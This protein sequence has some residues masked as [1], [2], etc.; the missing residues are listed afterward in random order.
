MGVQNNVIKIVF[1]IFAAI[2]LL[3]LGIGITLG[4]IM[5][6]NQKEMVLHEAVITE[7]TYEKHNDSTTHKVYVDYMFDDV[8]YNHRNLGYW[9]SGMYEGKYIEIYVDPNSPNKIMGKYSTILFTAVFGGIGAVFAVIG[10]SGLSVAIIKKARN[11][12]L[13]RTG[14]RIY[15]VIESI[16]HDMY[17]SVNRRHPFFAMVVVKDDYT[18]EEKYYRSEDFWDDVANT[19]SIGDTAV[20]YVDPQKPNRYFVDVTG[21]NSVMGSSMADFY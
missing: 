6:G 5:G 10:I 12:K 9:S 11:K 2:G 21:A 13:F 15:G 8:Q 20:I 19:I 4:I 1:G 18:G 7:I 3:F 16:D 17:V 14:K